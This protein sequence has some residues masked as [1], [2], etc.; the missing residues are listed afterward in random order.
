[1]LVCGVGCLVLVVTS[2]LFLDWFHATLAVDLGQGTGLDTGVDH[3]TI[4][5]HSLRRCAPDGP[6][7]N[8]PLSAVKG[9]YSSSAQMSL[10][11]SLL[12]VCFVLFQA[13]SRI[14][15]G[16][17]SPRI[18]KFGYMLG[19]MVL[20]SVLSAGY[21]FQPESTTFAVGTI[22][23]QRTWAPLMLL[24]SYL[25]GFIAL[26]LAV[27]AETSEDDV[28]EYKPIVIP[29]K[30][31]AGYGKLKPVTPAAPRVAG[32]PS[33]PAPTRGSL[34]PDELSVN[35]ADPD[36]AKSGQPVGEEDTMTVLHRPGKRAP[37]AVGKMAA[38]IT[39]EQLR[40]KLFYATAIANIGSSGIEAKRED[41]LGLAKVV[42]W[43]DVVGVVARRLP[44]ESPYDGI[45]FVDVVSSPGATLRIL[46]WT[47]LNAEK[48]D[49]DEEDG[50]LRARAFVQ[51]V[52]DHCPDVH[53][54]PATR[55]FLGAGEAAQV[56]TVEVLAVHDAKLA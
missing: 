48:F 1:M 36:T 22:E 13:G 3:L 53:L 30:S 42:R 40:K 26:S 33:A 43:R 49:D 37:T 20:S 32:S 25:F 10:W 35:I 18:T 17:A 19:T 9:F 44:E 55:T 15:N 24:G 41:G 29:G 21:L 4:N 47:R 50:E 27:S 46:P 56:P 45:T 23:V 38:A 12:F 11:G 34:L 7:M 2:T 51:L 5:L 52:V 6:C 28:G 14:L 54:D 8:M 31:P 16:L 39:R